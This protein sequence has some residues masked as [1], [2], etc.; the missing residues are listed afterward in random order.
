M[1]SCLVHIG[2]GTNFA[3]VDAAERV[4]LFGAQRKCQTEE[5]QIES[6]MRC[7]Q[8]DTLAKIDFQAESLANWLQFAL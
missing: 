6:N 2:V 4:R 1:P 3:I 7:L 5:N 8:L